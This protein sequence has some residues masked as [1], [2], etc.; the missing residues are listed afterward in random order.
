MKYLKKYS[1]FENLTDLNFINKETVEFREDLVTI[2][3]ENS[4]IGYDFFI[5]KGD[6]NNEVI[7]DYEPDEFINKVG[8]NEDGSLKDSEL[9]KW[10]IAL[11]EKSVDNKNT[12]NSTSLIVN[13]FENIEL[14]KKGILKVS[15]NGQT[16]SFIIEEGDLDK[17]DKIGFETN[18]DKVIASKLG[19]ELSDQIKEKLLELY[20]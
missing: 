19:L 1:L 9:K 2:N 3:I 8:I 16:L 6:D 12:I 20:Y 10:L 4:D 15:Y 18:E 7:Y 11:T 14:L 17:D 13:K 5:K